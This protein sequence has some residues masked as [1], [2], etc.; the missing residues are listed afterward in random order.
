[1]SFFSAF[2]NDLFNK[3]AEEGEENIRNLLPQP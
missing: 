2:I 3:Y 1:M